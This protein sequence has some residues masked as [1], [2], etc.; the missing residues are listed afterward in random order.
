MK[1]SKKVV[2]VCLFAV[3]ALGLVFAGGK[4]D[5]KTGK[6]VLNVMGYGDNANAEG[7]QFRQ[8]CKVIGRAHV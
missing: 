6:V 7:E 5:S 8:I 3:L 4:S 1:L 2:L